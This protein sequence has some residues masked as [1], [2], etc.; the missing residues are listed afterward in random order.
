MKTAI[1]L[2]TALAVLALPAAADAATKNRRHHHRGYDAY[3]RAP[4]Q[5]AC[6]QYGCLPVQR[7]CYPRGGRTWSGAPSGFDVVVCPPGVSYYGN[8]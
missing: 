6:T 5:I 3:A 8:Y 1:A 7:G 4:G 2:A